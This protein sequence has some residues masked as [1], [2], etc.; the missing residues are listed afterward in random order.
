MDKWIHKMVDSQVKNQRIQESEVEIY[1]YGYRLLF[2]K[3]G[4]LLLTIM[5]AII[6]D[7]YWEVFF[8]C[9]AFIPL[10]VYT[11][12]YH[13]GNALCCMILS[14]FALTGN[15]FLVRWLQMIFNGTYFI[16]LELF[17]GI[18]LCYFSPVE[19][20]ERRITE[21]ERKYFRKMALCIFGIQVL[22]EII[23]IGMGYSRWI[24]SFAV[25]HGIN[26]ITVIFPKIKERI[27]TGNEVTQ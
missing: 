17:W 14:G 21:S 25:A 7:A 5:I 24:I 16:V 15:I 3:I 26:L 18:L 23:L 6:F 27:I 4:A 22:G 2:E 20:K 19:T 12:G 13:A 1:Q 10:R 8:F 11:G 9:V